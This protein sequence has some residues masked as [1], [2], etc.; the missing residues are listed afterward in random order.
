MKIL[1]VYASKYGHT[2]KVVRTVAEECQRDGALCD[3]FEVRSVP[4]Q[5]D[6]GRYDGLVLAGSVHYGKHDKALESFV[7]RNHLLSSFPS[8]MLSISLS[9]AEEKTRPEAEAALDRF[10]ER[11][12][13]TPDRRLCVAGALAYTR[14]G[15][16]VRWMMRRISAKKGATT[17]TSR[18]HVYTDWASLRTFARDFIASLEA[19]HGEAMAHALA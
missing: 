19:A 5:L 16:F 13:W 9:A 7:L 2:E 10:C 18:D 14:Y 3:T 11:T 4:Q 17:D 15:F 1:L 8:V 6:I 12:A